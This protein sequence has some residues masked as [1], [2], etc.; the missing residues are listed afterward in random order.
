VLPKGTKHGADYIQRFLIEKKDI[1]GWV[2]LNSSRYH[3]LV[4]QLHIQRRRTAFS[5]PQENPKLGAYGRTYSESPAHNRPYR[6][7]REA[8]IS[9]GRRQIIFR[10]YSIYIK[11]KIR[12]RRALAGSRAV[13]RRR[14]S[15]RRL[16]S[17]G[18]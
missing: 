15:I 17:A 11:S 14:E 7:P 9:G 12:N 18:N 16:I 4:P 10:F 3:R 5:K 6:F 13:D 8:R 2:H 1:F